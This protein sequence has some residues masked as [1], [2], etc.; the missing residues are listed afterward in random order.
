MRLRS[1]SLVA[2]R[3]QL[4]PSPVLRQH[5]EVVHERAH[6]RLHLFFLGAGQE[7]DVFAERNRHAR[8]DDFDEAVRF[9]RL[10]E[11]GGQREQGLAGARGPEDGDEVDFRIHEQVER[12]ILLAVAGVHAPDAVALAAKIA[13]QFERGGAGLDA[14]HDG[15]DAGFAG[16]L[17]HELVDVQVG[18][19]GSGHSIEGAVGLLSRT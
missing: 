1:R 14:P 2:A 12:E 15:L 5:L 16:F 11:P 8:H 13:R 3:P 18:D 7:A 4:P 10:H 19:H 6:P 9:Q 17:V